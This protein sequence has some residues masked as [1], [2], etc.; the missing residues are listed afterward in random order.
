M[1]HS[2]RE[3]IESRVTQESWHSIVDPDAVHDHRIRSGGRI[4][5]NWFEKK[6]KHAVG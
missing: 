4:M 1:T 3:R 5:N 2:W 6:R